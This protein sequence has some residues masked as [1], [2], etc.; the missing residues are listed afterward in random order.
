MRTYLLKTIHRIA[1]KITILTSPKSMETVSQS[2]EE[3]SEE[4][5]ESSE[6]SDGYYHTVHEW[7]NQPPPPIIPTNPN[8]IEPDEKELDAF[9]FRY[10]AWDVDEN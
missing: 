7:E 2:T 5:E 3:V 8:L 10:D 4:S 9:L 1:N 6:E